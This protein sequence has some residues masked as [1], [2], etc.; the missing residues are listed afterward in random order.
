M[1]AIAYIPI[2]WFFIAQGAK[3]CHDYGS[4]GWWQIVPFCPIVMI[5]WKGQ[6]E[7]NKYGYNPKI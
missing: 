6:P 5:F 4:S 2:Y 7:T 1:A 3:R